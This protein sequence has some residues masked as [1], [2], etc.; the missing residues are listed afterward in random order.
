MPAA[1][2]SVLAATTL[3]R[4]TECASAPRKQATTGLPVAAARSRT[5][6]ATSGAGG[7]ETR[8]MT[9]V[10][11]SA[12]SSA[13]AC[14]IEAPPIS[15]RKSRPPVPRACD[16]PTP[17]RP[18]SEVTCC[19]PVPDAPTTPTGPRC[20][21]LAK[22]S[23]T[24]LTIAVPQSG[25]ITSSPRCAASRLSMT[26]SATLTLSLKSMTCRP[27]RNA[28]SASAAAYSPGVDMR[29][30]LASVKPVSPIAMLREAISSGRALTED[31]AAPDSAASASAS[32]CSTASSVSPSSTTNKSL[33]AAWIESAII[34]A[35]RSN[36][37]LPSVAITAEALR[38]PGSAPMRAEICISDTESR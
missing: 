35:S 20:T 5:R 14:N 38:M 31:C 9:R 12:A 26:S 10:S 1:S 16:T 34:F 25:P 6:A 29:A 22:P 13:I 37:R 3:A 30:R 4:S 36:A 2:S 11:E 8:R 23:G 32:A 24:P 18:S 33:D 15:E 17:A 27:S 21:T 7:L 28:L 19:I